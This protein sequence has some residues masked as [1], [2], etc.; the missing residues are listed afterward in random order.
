MRSNKICLLHRNVVMER[1][2]KTR[3][4][5]EEIL[6]F[7]IEP[8][9][10]SELSD[11]ESSNEEDET[12]LLEEL[13]HET[14]AEDA[15]EEEEL[16]GDDIDEVVA[17][18]GESK[19]TETAK[20]E[21]KSQKKAKEPE[22]LFSW[23]K[24]RPTAVNTEFTGERF[25]LPPDDADKLTPSQYFKMFWGDELTALLAEQTKVYSVQKSG[26][27]IGTT[28]D[29]I[30]QLLGM[31]M[32]MSFVRLPSYQM[33]WA[34]ETRFPPVADIMPINRYKKLRQ[35]LHV[36]DSTLADIGENKGNRLYKTQPVLDHV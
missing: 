9:A 27:S 12:L 7:V 30:E 17:D 19:A 15:V 24:K 2:S 35:F 4:D 8:G 3:Y 25:S 1:H 33:F 28:R 21:K 34:S 14:L 36:S 10:D 31:Q 16:A 26:T 29:E 18:D 20:K 11:F 22:H 5:V 6:L 32:C 23:K 13:T